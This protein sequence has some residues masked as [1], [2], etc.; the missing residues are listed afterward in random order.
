MISSPKVVE[1]VGIQSLLLPIFLF[2]DFT[3]F[4]NR[5]S[6]RTKTDFQPEIYRHFL[7][8]LNSITG[9]HFY[10]EFKEKNS[11]DLFCLEDENFFLILL[12]FNSI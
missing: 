1:E 6:F 3:I 9:C 12:N 7:T 10:L 11:V 2:E 4:A 8:S 5:I